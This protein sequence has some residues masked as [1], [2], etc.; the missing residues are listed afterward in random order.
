MPL[1]KTTYDQFIHQKNQQGGFINVHRGILKGQKGSGALGSFIGGLIKKTVGS[2]I[3][4]RVAKGL[5]RRGANK[6]IGAVSK[7]AFNAVNG[8]APKKKKVKKPKKKIQPKRKASARSGKVIGSKT[9][10]NDR[11]APNI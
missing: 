8:G 10:R 2:G 11:F 6:A 1:T 7:A 9:I 5:L 4:G 3:V